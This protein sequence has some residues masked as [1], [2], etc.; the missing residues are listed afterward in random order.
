MRVIIP[1]VVLTVFHSGFSAAQEKLIQAIDRTNGTSQGDVVY[2]VRLR[3]RS[4]DIPFTVNQ[5]VEGIDRAFD[6]HPLLPDVEISGRFDERFG[7]VSFPG[8]AYVEWEMTTKSGEV[9]S[10]NSLGFEA[11]RPNSVEVVYSNFLL[12]DSVPGR[13]LPD[14]GEPTHELVISVDKDTFIQSQNVINRTWGEDGPKSGYHLKDHMCTTFMA[15]VAK[16]VG[17]ENAPSATLMHPQMYASTLI[18]K[19]VHDEALSEFIN[20]A[21]FLQGADTVPGS[22]LRSRLTSEPASTDGLFL[23]LKQVT[24]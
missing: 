9:L 19:T 14:I 6:G 23:D 13:L 4:S 22:L 10:R 3:A 17:I 18:R 2:K 7:E 15:E 16:A 1:V 21:D 5:V 20:T 12:N 8:H 11:V 24:L